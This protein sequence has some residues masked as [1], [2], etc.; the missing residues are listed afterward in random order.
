MSDDSVQVQAVQGQVVYAGSI[1]EPITGLSLSFT[2]T[3]A[4]SG[5]PLTSG[6]TSNFDVNG[7]VL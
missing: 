5:L 4:I 1:C 3:S 6:S 7:I 2:A